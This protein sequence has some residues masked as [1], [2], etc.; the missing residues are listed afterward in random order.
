[1]QRPQLEHVIRAAAAITG[2]NEII[3][4]GSQAV[5]GQF[6]DAPTDLLVSIEADVFT[7]RSP[8]DAD[9]IDG[10]IGEGSPFH[11]TFGYY[12]HG[13]AEETAILPAGWKNRLVTVR[14]ANTGNGCGMCLEVHDL[15]VAK[16]AAGREKDASFIAGLLRHKLALPTLIESRL[17]QSDLSGVRLE[18][19]LARLKRLSAV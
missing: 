7:F 16:L 13:V 3:V 4:I 19:A 8:A 2:A 10:S 9:L 11:Q 14:N 17:H 15:A 18:L 5:L 1:M 6:P 12:A